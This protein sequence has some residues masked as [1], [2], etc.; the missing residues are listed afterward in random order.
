MRKFSS[1][2]FLAI[3]VLAVSACSSSDDDL[4]LGSRDD[5]IINNNNMPN[6][7]AAEET[8]QAKI[9]T[10]K[11]DSAQAATEEALDRLEAAVAPT[12]TP[13][14]APTPAPEVAPAAAPDAVTEIETQPM[15]TIGMVN[16]DAPKT[17]EVTTTASVATTSAAAPLPVG[18]AGDVPPNARPGE[19]YAKV[20]IP[21]VTQTRSERVQISEEQQVLNRIIPARYEV[22]RE[23]VLVSEAR[24]YW[25]AGHGPV[26]K[27]DE[28]TGEIMCLVEEPAVYKTLEKRVL[29]EPE[30][31]E[32]RMVPAQFETVTRTDIVQPESWQ[33]QRIL[34]ETNM[35]ANS[36]QRIQQAL[37]SKGYNLAV[38][39]KLGN[40]TLGAINSYQLKYGLATRGITYETLNHLGVQLIGA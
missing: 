12:A 6:K 20:L 4:Y 13:A 29:I 15:E 3:A 34:C 38:D 32:Y 24:Q 26:T 16:P 25:K 5:I 23:R 22:Q 14:P 17:T 10:V 9:E 7:K 31:P 2:A 11:A 27:K 30:K 40:A 19:C 1:L 39:G 35:G 21:A 18:S 33:W 8:V 37:N 36:I 28:V